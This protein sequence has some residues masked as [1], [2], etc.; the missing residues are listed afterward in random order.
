M[1]MIALF[2]SMIVNK[3]FPHS[4]IE[5]D[6]KKIRNDQRWDILKPMSWKLLKFKSL[7]LVS[8]SDMWRMK[9]YSQIVAAMIIHNVL[10]E[11]N[12]KDD[13]RNIKY[14]PQFP[15]LRDK[16]WRLIRFAVECIL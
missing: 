16:P 7:H 3:V 10:P 9:E 1:E 12:N 2:E 14:D 11:S 8:P 13:W 15:L 5:S 6:W 4:A